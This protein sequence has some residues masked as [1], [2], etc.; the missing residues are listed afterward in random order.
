MINKRQLIKN[1]I[2]HND[3]CSFFD[4]KL[5]IDLKSE[6]AP[7]RLHRVVYALVNHNNQ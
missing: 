5:S 2:S 1:I 7:A 4:K 6:P 3:E